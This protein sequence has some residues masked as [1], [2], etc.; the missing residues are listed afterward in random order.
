M[1][2]LVLKHRDEEELDRSARLQEALQLHSALAALDS[3]LAQNLLTGDKTEVAQCM[4]DLALCCSAR[5]TLY[6]L[7]GCNEPDSRERVA[8]ESAMQSMALEGI[9]SIASDRIPNIARKI[10]QNE[11]KAQEIG[12][13]LML[14]SLYHAATEAQWFLREGSW[15]EMEPAIEVTTAALKLLGRRWKVAGKLP[16][17]FLDV[18]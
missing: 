5:L 4:I 12:S 1:L 14:Q 10:L 18:F 15:P 2:G 3:H 8:Q 11:E 6:N 16:L 13:P 9:R 17:R 7:Y